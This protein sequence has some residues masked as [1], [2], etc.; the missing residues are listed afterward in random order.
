MRNIW[1]I[2][3]HDVRHQI[4]QGGTLVWLLIM[5]PIFF[6]FIGTVMGGFSS[7]V[8]GATA[9]PLLVEAAAPGFLKEQLDLRLRDNDFAPEWRESA[10]KVS[11]EEP[12]PE[13]VLRFDD[14]LTEQ[15]G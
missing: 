8:T 4:R 13:R 3:L 2:A 7:S 1:F 12:A 5:P 6:Y 9:T 15:L 14:G 10:A 11:D